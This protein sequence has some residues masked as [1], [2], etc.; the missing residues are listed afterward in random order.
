MRIASA[1]QQLLPLAHHPHIFI[2]QDENLDRQIILHC[3]RHFL[4][5]HLHRGFTGNVDDKGIG[6]RHLNADRRG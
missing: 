5:G 4:H 2:V 1:M 3:R 6:V